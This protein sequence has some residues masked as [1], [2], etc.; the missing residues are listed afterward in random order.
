[1]GY[2]FS[3]TFIGN[4]L[5]KYDPRGNIYTYDPR[6]NFYTYDPRGNLYAY[7]PRG[8]FILLEVTRQIRS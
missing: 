3:P 4:L 2:R 1:M 6:G 5:N 8:K 7:D